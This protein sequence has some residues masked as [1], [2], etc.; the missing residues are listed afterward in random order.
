MS[1]FRPNIVVKGKSLQPFEE[2][3]WKVIVIGTTVF[4]IVK[5]CPRC[6]QSCTDQVT[7]TVSPQMEPLTT[8]A[9]FRRS[10]G[11]QPTNGDVFFA[12]NAIPIG[13]LEG[14][15]IKVGDPI[16]VLERGDPVYI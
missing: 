13:T 10:L 1:R 14:K 11:D 12:Q 9:S 5:A 8:M 3:R 7:G 4:A 6:K 2:D 15:T 16:E